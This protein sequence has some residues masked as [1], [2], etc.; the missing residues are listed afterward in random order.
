MYVAIHELGHLMTEEIG[1]PQSFWGNFKILLKEAV[2]LGLYT[3]TDYAMKPVEYCGINIKSSV[4][5][6]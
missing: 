3:K 5:V 4:L 2:N 6:T 1:H